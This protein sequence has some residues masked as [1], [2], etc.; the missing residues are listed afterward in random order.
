MI[1]VKSK[2]KFTNMVYA[3][4]KLIFDLNFV[5]QNL[6]QKLLYH[7]HKRIPDFFK[8]LPDSL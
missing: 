8:N 1:A 2:G 4:A 5:E 7:D 6:I 3:Y